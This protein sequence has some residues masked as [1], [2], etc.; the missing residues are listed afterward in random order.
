MLNQL[1][2]LSDA[3][4]AAAT[5]SAGNGM[6]A[7]E[8]L[9]LG[10]SVMILGLV[11]VF[12]GLV[13]LIFITWLYPKIVK[14]LFPKVAA[15]KERKAQKK[16]ERLLAKREAKESKSEKAEAKKAQPA[17]AIPVSVSEGSD[18]ALIAV[19]TAAIAASLGTSTNGIVIKSL[20]R[21]RPS[22]P[23][24]GASARVEQISNRL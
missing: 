19:I 15:A 16:A 7:L 23:A 6:T 21:A 8:S 9:G 4:T 24:W 18:P 20:R 2:S 1:I 12:T 22:L 3:A 14:A 13:S 11:I 10:G 17:P 5:T